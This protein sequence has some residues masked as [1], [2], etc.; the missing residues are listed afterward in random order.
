[1]EFAPLYH[2]FD[3]PLVDHRTIFCH[4]LP[5]EPSKGPLLKRANIPKYINGISREIKLKYLIIYSLLANP[6]STL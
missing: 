3:R 5:I 1:M 2:K 4:N 6:P